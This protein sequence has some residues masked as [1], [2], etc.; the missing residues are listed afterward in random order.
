MPTYFLGANTKDGFYSL[1]RNFPPAENAFLHVIKGGPGTGKSSLLRAI[2]DAGEARGLEVHRVLC[3][4]DPD[5]LDGVYLPAL[6]LAWVDG[7]APHV[8]E[9]GLFG[10]DGDYVNLTDFFALPF[11]SEEK[12]RL[13]A[14]QRE[15]QGKYREAYGL[16][17]ACSAL[18][19]DNTASCPEAELWRHID[20]LPQRD[21][22]GRLTRRFLSAISCKGRL[23]L[24]R[25]LDG[26]TVVSASPE[27]IG[28]AA[29]AVRRRGWNGILCPSP[30]DPTQAEALLLPEKALAFTALSA[31]K[32][33]S[34]VLMSEAIL[35]LKE[36]K[37]LHDEMEAVYKPHM[38]FPALSA[39]THRLVEQV[40]EP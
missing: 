13:T 6:S 31:P 10:V 18:G 11:S 26:Y 34:L 4:G 38:D 30:L 15:Y 9:P 17:A 1:Y 2:A 33:E 5:S 32:Q 23:Q 25:E 3:S 37:A 28:A 22:P 24:R 16:L 40:F 36:A 7:T 14:L 29:Q 35:R 21:G 8:Q 19:G 39:Y 20:A 27:A 12:A